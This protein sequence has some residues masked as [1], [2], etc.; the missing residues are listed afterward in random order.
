MIGRHVPLLLT[1]DLT[2]TVEQNFPVTSYT[3]LRVLALLA[4]ARA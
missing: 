1:L 3:M 4:A 2:R